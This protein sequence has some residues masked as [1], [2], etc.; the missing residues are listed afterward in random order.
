MQK[1]LPFFSGGC[2]L[3]PCSGTSPPFCTLSKCFFLL[4]GFLLALR[5]LCVEGLC[6]WGGPR[7][8]RGVAVLPIRQGRVRFVT[9]LQGPGEGSVNHSFGA[10]SSAKVV[11]LKIL[12]VWRGWILN[13][14]SFNT[15]RHTWRK[16]CFCTLD[17]I[18][19]GIKLGQIYTRGGWVF[20]QAQGTAS[21]SRPPPSGWRG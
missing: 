2:I 18:Q 21:W 8:G 11:P 12:S 6:L 13:E 15:Q 1:I 10:V 16:N 17:K 5:H 19:R 9:V 7:V 20:V 4:K 3:R 14:I